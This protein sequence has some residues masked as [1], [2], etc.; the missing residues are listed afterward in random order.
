MK[1]LDLFCK[2]GGASMGLRNAGFVVTGVDCE[3]QPHYP[4]EFWQCDALGFSLDG[5]DLVWASPPCQVHS[6]LRHLRP[7]KHYECFISRIRERLIQWGG[8]WIIENVPGAPLINPVV[9]CGSSFGLKVRR[10]RLFESNM[11]LKG[12]V[13]DHKKQGRPID[14]SGT[15]GRRVNRRIGDHGGNT[16]K[17]RSI[18]EAQEAMGI[19]WMTRKE[20]AQAIPPAY[21]EFL[22]V[23]VIRILA[24]RKG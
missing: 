13:C 4:F 7:E 3:Y 11:P 23:Q 12:S 2:A 10:H 5:F 22:G 9:L 21:S 8:A 16:N 18:K 14:V 20:L 1:A 24:N 17:P 19:D 6:A 15:G